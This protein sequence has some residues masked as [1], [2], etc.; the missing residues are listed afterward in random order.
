[1]HISQYFLLFCA[2]TSTLVKAQETPV[3][4]EKIFG[5]GWLD[6]TQAYSTT[7]AD[8]LA[9]QLDRFF[10]VER[11]DLEAAYSSLRLIL[12][13]RWQ[14]Q[15]ISDTRVRLRGTLHLPRVSERLSL[16]FS[17]DQGEGTTYYAQNAV[18]DTPRGTRVNLEVNLKDDKNYR[19]DFRI[20]LRSNLKLRSSVRY[21]YENDLSDNTHVR[22][23]ETVY[24]IDGTGYGSFTQLQLDRS[25]SSNALLRWSTEFRSQEDLPGNEWATALQYNV[26]APDNEGISYFVG[27]NGNS[28][29]DEVDHYQ[30]GFRLRRNFARPWLFWEISPGIEWN[31]L[32]LAKS[33]DSGLFTVLRL[34]MAIGSY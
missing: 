6:N 27:M 23:S 24:F 13:T 19:F 31:K 25:I 18:L 26:L 1:M 8:A 28:M 33:Y 21:R 34:E 12:E 3:E 7:Q 22:L 2:C 17:E 10:G 30:A 11:S 32:P 20:G 9:R 29:H 16:I 15:G 5:L 14:E 4:P